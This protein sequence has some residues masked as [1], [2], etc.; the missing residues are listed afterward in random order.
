MESPTVPR[1]SVPTAVDV[2]RRSSYLIAAAASLTVLGLAPAHT[3]SAADGPST[4]A[5]ILLQDDAHHA[6][7]GLPARTAD[8]AAATPALAGTL[9]GLDVSAYQGNVNWS[10]VAANGA[11]FALVKATESTNYVSGSFT[12]QY[13]GSAAAGLVRGAYHFAHPNASTGAVQADYF[14][15]H[16]GGWMSDGKT[17]PGALD[18]EYNPGT[19][20]TCYGLTHSGMINWITSFNTQ[21]HARTG[22]YPI[23]YSTTDWWTT[24]T[25]NYSGFAATDPLWIANYG[26]A[27]SPLPNGWSTYTIWQTASSGPFP[28]DQDLFNGTADDLRTFALGDYAPPPP[29]V[30]W[31]YVQQGASGRRVSTVQYLLNAHGAALPVDGAF[32]AGTRGAV[33]AF[34]SANGLAADGV[35]GPATWQK[36][37]ITVQQGSTGAAVQAAQAEL[38]AHGAALTVDGDFGALT[39]SAVKSYQ[40]SRGLTANGIVGTDTWESLVS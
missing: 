26:S 35:V 18:I 30:S 7:S 38:N 10:T 28:G 34:Q 12:Q 40:T 36:L 8:P 17:L 4:P 3:A 22:R 21:Y 32:G 16:G 20:G 37:V 19:G 13:N 39:S 2:R 24:C 25:G 33:V 1:T 11:S 23:I 31:P 27:P 5:A 6:G 15:N 9:R 29:P 14:V